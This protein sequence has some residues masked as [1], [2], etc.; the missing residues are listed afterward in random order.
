MDE[1]EK[2]KGSVSNNGMILRIILLFI[3]IFFLF[4]I[5]QAFVTSGFNLLFGLL[6]VGFSLIIFIGPIFKLQKS[7]RLYQRLFPNK[8]E[9]MKR[10]YEKK[11]LEEKKKK[12]F[13]FYKKKIPI[14][15]ELDYNYKKSM[16]R[17]CFSC[18]I[19]IP[20]FVK[21]CPNCGAA[22]E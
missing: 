20:N 3:Y 9:N 7:K 4:L 17:K 6:L 19:I 21:K 2:K 16:I 15:I 14:P 18:G 8:N 12:D 13:E 5:Y 22:L 1:I 10:R 11:R